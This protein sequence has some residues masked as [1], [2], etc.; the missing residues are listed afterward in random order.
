[1]NTWGGSSAGR[2]LRSQCRGRGFDP[3]PL[4]HQHNPQTFAQV[5]TSPRTPHKSRVFPCFQRAQPSPES[6]TSRNY[7]TVTRLR[8]NGLLFSPSVPAL[9]A[10]SVYNVTFTN[11]N[12]GASTLNG[13]AIPIL[14]WMQRL[15]QTGKICT[16]HSSPRWR[17]SQPRARGSMASLA[18]VTRRSK[19][20]RCRR[21]L[22][23]ANGNYSASGRPANQS[24]RLSPHDNP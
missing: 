16:R 2:A 23:S 17:R 11:A 4:H 8:P 3:L 19:A 24:A 1:L 7:L 18:K 14:V 20:P 5:R 6:A 13:T 12:T 15:L 21:L 22:A 9:L 10:G